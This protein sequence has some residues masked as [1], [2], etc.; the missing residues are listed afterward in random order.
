LVTDVLCQ[1]LLRGQS[2]N[3]INGLGPPV[4]NELTYSH[5]LYADDIIF[6]LKAYWTNVEAMLWALKA[7]EAP[8]D[9]KINYVKIELVSMNLVESEA[10][11]LVA[12]LDCKISSFPI[13]YLGVLLHNKKL[14][15]CD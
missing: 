14:R 7:F 8:S 5:F 9:I 2:L 11:S 4:S 10:Q 12:L 3:L 1:I 13:K 6:F 15:T